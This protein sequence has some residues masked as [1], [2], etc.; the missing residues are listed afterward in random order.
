MMRSR[1]LLLLVASAAGT[2]FLPTGCFFRWLG[3]FTAD[4]LVLQAIP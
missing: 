2:V 4:A 1:K 3:D